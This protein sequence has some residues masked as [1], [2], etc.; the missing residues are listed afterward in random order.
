[1]SSTFIDPDDG[2]VKLRITTNGG[3]DTDGVVF[4]DADGKVKTR[5]S[6]DGGSFPP[7]ADSVTTDSIQD[8]A[9]TDAKLANPKVNKAGDTMTGPIIF[10]DP[11]NRSKLILTKYPTGTGHN[12][13]PTAFDLTSVYLHLGGT[14]YNTNSYRLISFGYR[15]SLDSSHAAAVIGYQE[16]SGS[17]NDMGRLLF[18]TRNVTTDTAPTVRLSIEP[19]GQLILEAGYV[20]GSDNAVPNKKYVDE[21]IKSKLAAVEPIADPPTATAEDAANAYNDL[22]Q[23][24]QS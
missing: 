11:N 14:E 1:M 10:A 4:I 5:V 24:L 15:H 23:A 3:G 16:T 7:G 20:P 9:V 8:G 19:D 18:A 13:A 21:Y 12:N 6:L 22:L 2:K 17:G